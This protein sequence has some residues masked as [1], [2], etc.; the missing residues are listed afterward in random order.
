MLVLTCILHGHCSIGMLCHPCQMRSQFEDPPVLLNL[1][2]NIR[3]KEV[4][5]FVSV[6]PFSSPVRRAS[7]L[8]PTVL[9]WDLSTTFSSMIICFCISTSHLSVSLSCLSHS[10]AA[11]CSC[12]RLRS[13]WHTFWISLATSVSGPLALVCPVLTFCLYY[14]CYSNLTWLS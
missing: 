11:S 14:S 1:K 5:Y 2:R 13:I 7:L 9:P 3:S 6:T 8:A 4:R 12:S 10:A